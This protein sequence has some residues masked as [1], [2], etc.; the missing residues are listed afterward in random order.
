MMP[1]L[2][3]KGST[4]VAT[5]E[6][7]RADGGAD[8]L[9]AVLQALP[10]DL[11]GRLVAAEPTAELAYDDL[12]ALWREAD[13]A[14]A[15]SD[16]KWME[17]AGGFSIESSGVQMYGG[18]LRKATPEQFL[19]QSVSLFRLYYHPGDMVVVEQHD[20]SA[21]LRLVGFDARTPLFC[22]R[23]TGG[24]LAALT[25]AGGTSAEVHHVRCALD[26]DAWCEWAL[27]WK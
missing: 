15:L 22:R 13:T 14:L 19:T 23:Q 8:T 1:P 27:S 26:G 2:Y 21:V 10:A 5:L 17:R 20:R 4:V 7:L 24:L 6:F 16:P 18:L 12:V 3:A 9:W 25:I 11:R